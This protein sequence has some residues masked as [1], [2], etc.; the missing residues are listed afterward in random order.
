MGSFDCIMFFVCILQAKVSI[1]R[2]ATAVVFYVSIY[3]TGI[4]YFPVCLRIYLF[5]ILGVSYIRLLKSGSH[6]KNKCMFCLYFSGKGS[7][8]EGSYSSCFWCV[9][10]PWS[11]KEGR[12]N[13]RYVLGV[14]YKRPCMLCIQNWHLKRAR[15]PWVLSFLTAILCIQDGHLY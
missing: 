5:C 10:C 1:R 4:T 14:D 7:N 8:T 9:K 2:G 12:I 11:C 3:Y 15:S 6:H 13:D